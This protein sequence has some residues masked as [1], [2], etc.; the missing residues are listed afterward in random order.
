[1]AIN[2]VRKVPFFFLLGYMVPECPNPTSHVLGVAF[3]GGSGNYLMGFT[4]SEVA[5]CVVGRYINALLQIN[6]VEDTMA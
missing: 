6:S 1:M 3:S 5:P 4:N 2:K